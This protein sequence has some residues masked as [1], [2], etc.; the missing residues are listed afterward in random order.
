MGR[1]YPACLHSGIQTKHPPPRSRL[2]ATRSPLVVKIIPSLAARPVAVEKAPDDSVALPIYVQVGKVKYKGDSIPHVILPTLYK[3]PPMEFKNEA[4]R[5]EYN[6]LVSNIKLLLPLAKLVRY[7]IIETYDYLRLLPDKKSRQA[8]IDRMEAD[9]K[10]RYGPMIRK[11]TRSQGRLLLKLIDRECNQ[12][13]Y[14]IAKAFI[15]SFRANLYQ[16]IGL[17]FGNSLSRHY[18]PN[19]DDRYT[20]RVVRLVESGQI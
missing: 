14:N 16:S 4:E 6:R 1:P 7:T 2:A 8:H 5:Q 15:G 12:T 13:G 11:L 18:D 19:G 20:E 3:Y 9:L 17:L 10:R